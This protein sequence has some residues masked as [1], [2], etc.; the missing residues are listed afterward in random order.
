[1]DGVD[2]V[3][4]DIES[5][6][7]ATLGSV[8][9]PYPKSLLGDLHALCSPSE[10]E[11]NRLGQ[12]DRQ[13]GQHFARAVQK[14]LV[15]FD[16]SKQDITAIGSHGQT[17]RHLPSPQQTSSQQPYTE[18]NCGF[19]LQ[20]GDAN[21]IACTTD[22]DVIADF[23][24]KDIALGGQ[25]AP[26]VPIFHQA[27]FQHHLQNRVIVNIGGIANITVL[28]A[29]SNDIA[30]FDT[31]P[32]NTLLD[33]WA[34]R[35]INQPFDANGQW[36]ATG[37]SN[38]ALLRCLLDD[39]FFAKAPPKS[40]GREYFNLPWLDEKLALFDPI[41]PQNTQATL[42]ELTAISIAEAVKPYGVTHAF[43]CGGGV[44]NEHLMAS[45]ERHLSGVKVSSTAALNIDPQCVEGA[46]FAW[47]AYAFMHRL[48]GN[49]PSVT[50]ARRAA[51]LGAL[52]TAC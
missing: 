13:V 52:Y 12:V 10:N 31:G 33:H 47:L 19:S 8:S 22:I 3:L 14:L 44:R 32:G 41:S 28:P 38:E 23:R 4:C 39:P 20:I 34:Q 40:T 29:S 18:Q 45:I 26:L 43:M 17:I 15:T 36:G 7:F 1:M 11:I 2:A 42:V 50:G 37:N 16:L 9:L 21:T 25:G 48:P 46:A 24:R 27:Q 30:G 35:H 6:Y 49:V 5:D 51:V